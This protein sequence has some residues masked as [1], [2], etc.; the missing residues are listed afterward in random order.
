MAVRASEIRP[1]PVRYVVPPY[2][3][4]GELTVVTGA[5]G[6]GKTWFAMWIAALVTSGQAPPWLQG[7]DPPAPGRVL[8][9]SAEASRSV[10]RDRLRRQGA[11]LDRVFL[12]DPHEEDVN[13][14]IGDELPALVLLDPLE[15]VCRIHGTQ[16]R[17]HLRP[18]LEAARSAGSAALAVRH[19][20]KGARRTRA[21]RDRG[22]G[23]YAVRAL[24]RSELIWGVSVSRS[25]TRGFCHAK[26][27]DAPLG[28]S[29]EFDLLGGRLEWLGP[30]GLRAEDLVGDPP[31]PPRRRGAIESAMERLRGVL[32]EGSVPYRDVR[33]QCVGIPERTLR[34]AATRLCVDKQR[35]RRA[36]GQM[37]PTVWSLPANPSPDGVGDRL[38]ALE[39]AAGPLRALA[40]GR[41]VRPAAP[42]AGAGTDEVGV[43]PTDDGGAEHEERESNDADEEPGPE[44][45]LGPTTP[46]VD[47]IVT[48]FAG[49]DPGED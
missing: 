1:A 45:A 19:E 22:A 27:N 15:D 33:A 44:G 26:S 6:T 5:E 10:I 23:S 42:P 37:G 21:D 28:D 9:V 39:E 38:D 13:Q 43:A 4:A 47:H 3:P 18:L 41:A 16:V 48:R 14:S 8:Y 30:S 35:T 49:F 31:R 7:H 40:G 12:A 11:D 17:A 46:D 32:A 24:A 36:G 2:V 34:L 29:Q 25:T 20:A